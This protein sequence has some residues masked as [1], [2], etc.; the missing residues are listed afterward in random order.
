MTVP[1][2]QISFSL[3]CVLGRGGTTGETHGKKK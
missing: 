1:Y 3:Q 2:M